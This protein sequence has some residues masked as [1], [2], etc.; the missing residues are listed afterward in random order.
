MVD[1]GVLNH[2]KIYK[3]HEKH[4][5]ITCMRDRRLEERHVYSDVMGSNHLS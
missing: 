1:A 2:K 5:K 4:E 3:H